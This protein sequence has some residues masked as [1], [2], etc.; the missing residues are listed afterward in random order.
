MGCTLLSL[1][2][3]ITAQAAVSPAT[4]KEP[5][6]P[7]SQAVVYQAGAADVL[8]IKVFGEDALSNNYTVDSDGSITFPLIG[9]VQVG[10]LTTRQIEERLT[11]M[12]S[13]DYIR[14]PQVSVEIA[15]FR[16]RS[17]FVLGE[18][19]NPGR[20]TIQGPQTLLE[21]IAHAGSTTAAAGDTIIVQRYKDGIANAITA[22]LPDDERT[23]EVMRV[24]FE[25]LRQGRLNANILLQDSDTIIVPPADRFYVQG[26]VK[27]PGSFVLRPGMTV[28]QAIAEAGGITE[29][30]SSRRIKIVRKVKDKEVELDAEMSD[31]V[32][33]GDTIKVPQRLI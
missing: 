11:K 20:Y 32:R 25:D 9:R 30:G 33:P 16:S 24:S 21:L 6:L 5:K 2:L 13:G 4:P 1:V 17:I 23:A 3:L 31:L 7:A 26:F 12:L 14:N 19:K 28:R 29:R 8:G 22:A 18:V 15:T 10:G 27:Q